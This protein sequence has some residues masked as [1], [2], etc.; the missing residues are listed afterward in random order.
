MVTRDFINDIIYG[1]E[2]FKQ[3]FQDPSLVQKSRT[4]RV[5]LARAILARMSESHR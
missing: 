5:K 1:H 2:G 4:Y 3:K